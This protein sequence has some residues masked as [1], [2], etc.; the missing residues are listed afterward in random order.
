MRRVRCLKSNE[1]P[2]PMRRELSTMSARAH[3]SS[4]ALSMC[5]GSRIHSA[6]H[7]KIRSGNVRGLRTGYERHQRCHLI[8]APEAIECCVS[9]LR[10][11]PIAHGGIEIPIDRTRLHVVDRDAAA[12]NLS[13]ERLSKY[14]HD[15]LR[16]RV[17]H[18]PGYQDALTHR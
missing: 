3:P 7:G 16:G 8:G 10:Y 15:S 4:G 11:R 14:L 2:T 17:G 12:P 18:K 9:L 1:E 13:G 5:V 6:I